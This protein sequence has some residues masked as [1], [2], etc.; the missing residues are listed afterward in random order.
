MAPTSTVLWLATLPSCCLLRNGSAS[1]IFTPSCN[2][3]SPLLPYL[4]FDL[5][6]PPRFKSEE[7]VDQLPA[8]SASDPPF[9]K[10]FIPLAASAS[11]TCQ[12]R[13]IPHP[14]RSSPHQEQGRECG[15]DGNA[16]D[17][18]L[19]RMLTAPYEDPPSN[20]Y[21]VISC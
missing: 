17:D 16:A 10:K 8:R 5:D 14:K 19:S 3:Q 9:L 7:V 15:G 12:S 21:S 6:L 2:H 11:V 18:E 1:T 20:S 4:I 13:P